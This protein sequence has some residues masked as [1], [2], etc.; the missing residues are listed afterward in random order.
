[1]EVTGLYWSPQLLEYL[2]MDF[3]CL[4]MASKVPSALGDSKLREEVEAMCLLG[5]TKGGRETQTRA[6]L[7]LPTPALAGCQGD[8]LLQGCV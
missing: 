2:E 4:V 8:T 7:G 3:N 1:M 5:S 6:M